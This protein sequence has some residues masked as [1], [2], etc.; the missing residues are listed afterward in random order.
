MTTGHDDK[1]RVEPSG[2]L[3][4]C[5]WCVPRARLDE[6]KRLY[7]VSHGLCNA[8]AVRLESEAGT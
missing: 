8:C 3:K 4:V 2:I 7:T 5:A 6:L 1:V